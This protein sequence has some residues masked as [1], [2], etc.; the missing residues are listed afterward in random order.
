MTVEIRITPAGVLRPRSMTVDHRIMGKLV[1]IAAL[2][3]VLM[4][5]TTV[6][7]PSTPEGMRCVR[8][9]MVVRNTCYGG[10]YGQ[11]AGWCQIGCNGQQKDCHRTCPGATED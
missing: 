2:G 5:C 11:N 10:C 9:C 3:V 1:S 8:E 4:A 6:H 7:V